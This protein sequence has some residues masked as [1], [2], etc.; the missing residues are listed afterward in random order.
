M[1]NNNKL[2]T[3]ILLICVVFT[4]FTFT[5]VSGQTK[6]QK[7]RLSVQ[8]FKE[9]NQNILNISAK[10]KEGKKYKMAKGLDLKVYSVIENDSL[11]FLRDIIL[12]N[13]GKYALNV[14]NAFEKE[15]DVYTFKVFH[16]PSKEFKKATK[17]VEISIAN[18]TSVIRKNKEGYSIHATLT[19]ASN[20]PIEGQEL[21]VQLQRLFSPLAIGDGVH[22]TDEN[23]L[24]DIPVG[25]IM[26]GIDG[27]LNYEV[28]LEDSDDYGTIKSVVSTNIGKPIKDLST[29][30]ERTMWSPPI[31]APWAILIIPNLLIF[32]IWSTIFILIFNLYRISNHKNYKS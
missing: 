12:N 10:Y 26:P 9:E 23:G 27:K 1:K 11:V 32:G 3:V 20:E 4:T 5:V 8:Y 21:K 31:K 16:S 28:L 22:F 30:D 19:N 2:S 15:Q 14:N 29:F 7:A 18:L 13:S 17:T 6:K 25:E 24:I